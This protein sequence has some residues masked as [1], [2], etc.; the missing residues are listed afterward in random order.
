MA[1]VTQSQVDHLVTE[2]LPH[3]D[4]ETHQEEL[5]L[6]VYRC[7]LNAKPEYIC[8]FSRLQGLDVSNFAQSEGLKYYARTLVGAL[9][10][11]I[12]AGANK[13]ELD[14]LC[15]KEAVEHRTRQ[16]NNQTF[17][18][19]LPIFIEFFNDH[20]NDKQNKE[21][22]SKILTYVFTTIGSQI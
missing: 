22:M 17:L 7:F 15:L 8:K 19:S 6:K 21:T 1:A 18:D 4:T 12:K 9:V 3:V 5:G 13:F 14:K 16:V 10:P 20:I 11:I 2:L